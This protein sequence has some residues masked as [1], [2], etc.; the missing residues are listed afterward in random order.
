[1]KIIIGIIIIIVLFWFWLHW[2][3]RGT[4]VAMLSS[5]YAMEKAWKRQNPNISQK[6]ILV[7]TLQSR[8]TYKNRPLI[9]LEKIVSQHS[10]IEDLIKFVIQDE[11]ENKQS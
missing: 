11:K 8:A 1:M 9:E 7:K 5:Y 6:T 10:T 2:G 4:R 3:R